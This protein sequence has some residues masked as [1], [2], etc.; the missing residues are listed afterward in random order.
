MRKPLSECRLFALGS[1]SAGDSAEYDTDTKLTVWKG[2]K[3]TGLWDKYSNG[4]SIQLG[5]SGKASWRRRPMRSCLKEP[6][7]NYPYLF[8]E[9]AK[10]ATASGLTVL[11]DLPVTAPVQLWKQLE[12]PIL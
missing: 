9:E 1:T 5:I 10:L 12:L 3:R 11:V 4:E 2:Q 7:Q 8:R 6:Y